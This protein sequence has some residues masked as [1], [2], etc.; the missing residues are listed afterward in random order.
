RHAGRGDAE[1]RQGLDD[2]A[3][4]FAVVLVVGPAFDGSV[5]PV[6]RHGR[7]QPFGHAGQVA[8][9]DVVLVILLDPHVVDPAQR[10]FTVARREPLVGVADLQVGR[11]GS[12]SRSSAAA[13]TWSA[14]RMPRR[15]A[16]AR[17]FGIAL[18]PNGDCGARAS[19]LRTW[20]SSWIGKCRSDRGTV[21][22]C[23][24]FVPPGSM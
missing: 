14:T 10:R 4:L 2:Q 5:G 24:S 13:V 16:A 3:V 12:T 22:P 20:G 7:G 8:L 6:V 9:E 18:S 23:S 19:A 1:Q 15:R 11:A 21:L 17:I